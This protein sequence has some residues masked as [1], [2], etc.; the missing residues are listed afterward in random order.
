M[1]GY[2]R[3]VSASLDALPLGTVLPAMLAAILAVAE[4]GFRL[5]RWRRAQR[6]H[7]PEPP[8]G[9][10][11][12]AQLGLLALL[13]AFTFGIAASRFEG[14]RT[15]LLDEAN[16]IGTTWLRADFLEPPVRD[17]VRRLLVEYAD[18][19][20]VAAAGGDVDAALRH[21]NEAHRRLWSAAVTSAAAEPRSVPRGLFVTALNELIDLHAERAM[22]ALRSRIPPTIWLVLLS[23]ALM[24]FLA[25]GYQEGLAG[26]NRSP[27]L[28]LVAT[29]FA[30]V[31]W[32][33]VDL[34]R[35]GEGALRVSQHP[36]REVREMMQPPA[37]Q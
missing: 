12:A 26:A 6:E 9:G 17:E 15:A 23:V 8:V 24:S 32:L 20:L 16:A 18:V 22:A 25:V 11:V 37:A 14:R 2:A 5:G 27:A 34:D 21:A 35:P 36:M 1:K 33:L 13:L 10:M 4:V 28:L 30:A 7:E 31:L 19:R 29:T 3:H